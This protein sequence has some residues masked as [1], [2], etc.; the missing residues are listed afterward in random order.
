MLTKGP[1]V[2]KPTADKENNSKSTKADKRIN[3]K[4]TN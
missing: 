3:N 1:T 2:N 4:Q